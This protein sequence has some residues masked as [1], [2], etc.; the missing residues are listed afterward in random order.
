MKI[1]TAKIISS[2]FSPLVISILL[3]YVLVYA[4]RLDIFFALQWS[5]IS[6]L[7][8]F[9]VGLYVVYGVK[10]KFFSN[11]DVSKREERPRLFIF[12]GIICVLYFIILYLFDGPRVLYIGLGGLILGTLIAIGVNQKIKASIHMEALTAFATTCSLLFGGIFW[13]LF[14]L[15][16][17]VA[18]SRLTLRR[19]SLSEVIV[20]TTIGF[21]LVIFIFTVVKYS[22]A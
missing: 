10:K 12:T 21:V 14:L 9:I 16:P 20:G 17:I 18:W 5:F 13:Y 6:I 22:I 19:H 1:I 4:S 3:C 7:F 15:V 8:V 11:Y 2:V